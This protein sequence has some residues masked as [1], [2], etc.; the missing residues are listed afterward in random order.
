MIKQQEGKIIQI[1]GL[2]IDVEFQGNLP[3]ILCAI[4]VSKNEKEFLLEVESHIGK[5]VVRCIS[6]KNPIGLCRGDVVTSEGKQ[7]EIPVG[8]TVK[9]RVLDT[10]GNPLD[11][12]GAINAKKRSI[13]KNAPAFTELSDRINIQETGVKVIDL[14]T[15]YVL[16]GK[17]GFFGGAGV[18]KTVLITELIHNVA[19]ENKGYSVFIGSGER[20]REGLELYEAMLSSGVIKEQREESNTTILFGGMDKSP[21]ERSRVVQAGLTV[22]EYF[23]EEEKKDVLLFIDNIFRFIQ[24][25]AEI[26]TLMGKLPANVGYQATLASEIGQIQDRITCTKNGS[27]TSIQAVYV[28]ADDLSDPA[29]ATVFGHLTSKVVLS[30]D[31][32]SAGIFPAID[33]LLSSSQELS[34]KI[35]GEE[36]FNV[37]SKAK[38]V[39]AEYKSLKGIIAI[40]GIEDLTNDQKIVINRAR[41]I[42]NFLS[43]PFFT[44]EK[45]TGRPG[46][47]VPVKNTVKA[48]REILEGLYD[49]IHESKFYM[50]GDIDEAKNQGPN[51]EQ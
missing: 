44:A 1:N 31:I 33:P 13:H 49:H 25:G 2:V 39:I 9:G 34:E 24:A 35:V 36:H 6:I 45:F 19:I 7:I 43:Q 28:P 20:T 3:K 42:I 30:R 50:I 17:I 11:G 51:T 37:A 23:V 32:A 38:K 22:A 26:S 40:F 41:K 15:P 18:G 16:G 10:L 14:F 48:V 29:P 47:F 27:I 21:L 4:Y 8:P 5:N 46:K 12:L